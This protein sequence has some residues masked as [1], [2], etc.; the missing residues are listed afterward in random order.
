MRGAIDVWSYGADGQPG[1]EAEVFHSHMLFEMANMATEDGLVM[2]LHLGSM[3]NHNQRVMERFGPDMGADVPVAVDLT[4]GLQTLLNAF[5][6]DQR[7]RLVVY[8][9]DEATYAR[10][11]APLAGHYPALRLGSPWW[12]HDSVNGIQRYLA[13]TVETAGFHKLAGFVDDARALPT[14]RARHDV[15]R[16]V[17]CDWLARMEL[18]G[19]VDPEVSPHLAEWLAHG[20]AKDAFR[21]AGPVVG[22]VG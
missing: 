16:R 22:G 19:L 13:S 2:Q 8:T 11:L 21:V 10:E 6:Y 4:R 9:L 5:G 7:F 12:F 15:W 17:T 18:R 14:L 3:R 20:A 1:G